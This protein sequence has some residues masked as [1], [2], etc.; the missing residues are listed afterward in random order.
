MESSKLTFSKEDTKRI[1]D[2]EKLK[3]CFECG[4]CTASCSIAELMGKN[5]NPRSL[6]EKIF[7]N[8]EEVLN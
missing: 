6:L 2:A 1:L 5:Y 8:P 3:Y 4:I 7:L